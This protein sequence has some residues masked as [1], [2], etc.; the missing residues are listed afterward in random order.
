MA[1]TSF[2][3]CSQHGF[4]MNENQGWIVRIIIHKIFH[5]ATILRSSGGHHGRGEWKKNHNSLQTVSCTYSW[6]R[7]SSPLPSCSQPYIGIFS[8]F[9][10]ERKML[11]PFILIL[12]IGMERARYIDL[13]K[14]THIML[15][16][17]RN[18][19]MPS[20]ASSPSAV[21]SRPSFLWQ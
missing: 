14:A 10:L 3:V 16:Q 11:F 15:T 8:S 4:K 6:L 19:N 18:K 7:H 9:P 21:S 13:Q 20:S 2:V 12:E 17:T 1:S 5:K